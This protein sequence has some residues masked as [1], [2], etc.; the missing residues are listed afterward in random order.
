MNK[1]ASLAADASRPHPAPT[2]MRVPRWGPRAGLR[3]SSLTYA[4]YARSSRLAG[5]APRRPDLAPL[6]ISGPSRNLL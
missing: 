5:L 1:G 4:Q 2:P 3:C 6:F